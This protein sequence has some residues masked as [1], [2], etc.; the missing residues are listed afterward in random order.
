MLLAGSAALAQSLTI[1]PSTNPSVTAGGTQQFT[2][3]ARGFTISSVK[4][5]A[6]GVEGGGATNGK[7]ATGLTGGLYTAPT[8]LPGQN[9]VTITA[10]ATGTTNTKYSASVYVTI[11]PPPLVITSVTPNPLA[12][13]TINV[14]VSGA[15]LQS[16]AIVLLSYGKNSGIAMSTTGMTAG[17]IS[18]NGYLGTASS[19]SF[20]VK[21]P[22]TAC[23][24]PIVVPVGSTSPITYAL[25]VVHGSG[26]GSYAAATVVTI[27]ANAPPS[28]QQFQSWSGAT[29]ANASASTTT[30]TMPAANATVTAGYTA[31]AGLSITSVSPNPLP[32]GTVTV[33]ITGTGFTSNSAIWDNGVQYPAQQPTANTLTTSVYTALGTTSAVFSVNNAGKLSNTLTVPVAGPPTYTL[34]VVNGSGSGSYTAGT[35]V[36]ITANAAP[37]GQSFTGWTGA[38]VSNAN[39]TT[40]TIA[41]PANN[42][43][44]TA[45]FAPGPTYSLTVVGGSSSGN[46]AAG[47]AV[48]II[49]NNP[50]AGQSFLGWTGAT[51]ANASASTT[52]LTMPASAVTVTANFSQAAYT[53]TVVNGSGSGSYAAGTVVPINAGTAPAGQFFQAW[54]GSD[55][56]NPN[57]PSTTVTMPPANTTVSAS[58]AAAAPL[59][60]PVSTHPRLWITAADLPR[61]RGWAASGNPI[62]AGL[63]Q[64]LGT[65]IGNYNLAFPGAALTAK[66]PTP[67]SPFPDLGDTQGYQGILVEENAMIL[68]FNSMIDPSPSNRSAYA[69]AARNLIM[70]GLNQAAQGVLSGA[71]F[72]DRLFLT[73]NRGSYSGHEWALTVD[74]IYNAT[75]SL[76]QPILTAADKA[77]IQQVFLQWCNTLETASTTGGDSPQVV[78]VVNSVQLL[79]GNLPY[80]M[81][82]NNYYLAHARN[83]TMMALA[84]DPGDDPPVNPL[85]PTSSIGNT[86]R[87]WILDANGAWLYQEFA[88]MADPQVA[89]SALGV[90]NNPTGAGFGLASGGLPPEGFLYGESFGYVF[91]QLLSLETAGFNNPAI[92]G[93]QIGLIGAPVWDRYV[94][95]YLSSLTPTAQTFATE[96]WEGPLYQFAG[97]G[98]MLRLYVTPDAMRPFALLALLDQ[99]NGDQTQHLNAARWLTVNALAGGASALQSRVSDPWTWGA[100]LSILYF[101][102]L[103][104]S[105]AAPTDP[106][107]AYPTLFYD[108]P[109]GR[110]VAHSDWTPNGTM[111]DYKAT[112]TSIN[113]QDNTGGQ[114]ELFR[115]GEFLTKE[116]SNYDNNE[117]GL[118]TVYHNTLA[119]ENWSPAGTPAN[120]GWNEG[121]EWTNGSQ[122]M[123]GASAGDPTTI[124]SNGAGYVYASS[125]LTSMYNR[126]SVWSPANAA[127]DVLQATRSIVWLNGVVDNGAASEYV[128]VYDRA[129]TQQSGLF[130]QFNLSLVTAPVTQTGANGATISTETMSDG[131]QLFIQ[132]LLPRNAATGYFNGAQKLNPIA[133]LEPTQFIYTVQDPINPASTR[134]LHV[135]QGADSGVTM[136]AA[137]Y[138]QSTSGTAFDGAVFGGNAVFFPVS[139]IAP[140][141]GT[142]LPVPTGIHSVMVAGLAA[143][144]GYAVNVSNGAL[145]ISFGG[146]SIADSAGLLKITF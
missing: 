78:G 34:A 40:T 10:V 65:A 16:G 76:G 107:P 66:N 110:L 73:Y 63:T 45:N 7:I 96:P 131:Q 127:M 28:G 18:A 92:S 103:D 117:Q 97:Y 115:K 119:L 75:D 52:T 39:G 71:P 8:A 142:S 48:T 41:M 114:F 95:G 38:S 124:T 137:S 20:C 143:N 46:Y 112:W 26:S 139:S 109:Q 118:T 100:Q 83:M 37:A 144:A 27:A 81:A 25:T 91:D 122:W 98:D 105:A 11:A 55:V 30:L 136:V 130:K 74:W 61:L 88:M 132:T 13:G 70:Y 31:A 84:L 111:F 141:A 99:E 29:V 146:A 85:L 120:L 123:W 93:P 140:F 86:A 62:Y 6:G 128:V 36:T 44:V 125:D 138:V 17:S 2:A 33:T 80:R 21:N 51:V 15:G 87:S 68:A 23:S 77:V 58:F 69:Q 135:L 43:T 121:T 82:S 54:S 67:A 57:Q 59:P 64:V 113:H 94:T 134:F 42:A 49:A 102:L 129:Q 19:A 79:P 116:M 3:T 145:T 22:G 32:T 5:E 4:W 12:T 53:L 50:Q 133:E 108:A 106:R 90:P 101:L 1:A 24:N 126:P 9:P 72:R 35:V 14:T 56:A 47:A 104:P 89:A 60:F